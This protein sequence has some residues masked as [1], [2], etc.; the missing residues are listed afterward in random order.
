MPKSFDEYKAVKTPDNISGLYESKT[1]RISVRNF[2][3]GN[4]NI[5]KLQLTDPVEID[6]LSCGIATDSKEGTSVMVCLA[7]AYD[8]VVGIGSTED[9]PAKDMAAISKK[10]IEAWK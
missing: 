5:L 8:G 1:K 6:G 9:T 3:G 2:V 7:T 4:L 10:F